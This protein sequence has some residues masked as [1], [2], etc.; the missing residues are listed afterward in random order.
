[1]NQIVQT[2]QT[3]TRKCRHVK[4]ASK[5]VRRGNENELGREATFMKKSYNIIMHELS[6]REV[7]FDQ[8]STTRNKLNKVEIWD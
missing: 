3:C 6:N 8:W 1:M 2:T 5:P 4:K 7:V